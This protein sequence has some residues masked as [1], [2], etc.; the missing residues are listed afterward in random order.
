MNIAAQNKETDLCNVVIF[1]NLVVDEKNY[2][3]KVKGLSDS[4]RISRPAKSPLATYDVDEYFDNLNDE[5][6]ALLPVKERYAF[7]NIKSHYKRT[8]K[9][10][11]RLAG[12]YPNHAIK[13]GQVG[14]INVHWTSVI[15]LNIPGIKDAFPI[16]LNYNMLVPDCYPYLPMGELDQL[17]ESI[18]INSGISRYLDFVEMADYDK[19][20]LPDIIYYNEHSERKVI[21][22][23]AAPTEYFAAINDLYIQEICKVLISGK[24]AFNTVYRQEAFN[25]LRSHIIQS[26]KTCMISLIKRSMPLVIPSSEE[27]WV[28]NCGKTHQR[29]KFKYENTR[30]EITDLGFGSLCSKTGEDLISLEWVEFIADDEQIVIRVLERPVVERSNF[31]SM[32][33]Q[34]QYSGNGN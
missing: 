32:V 17:F 28:L 27:F 6:L 14:K 30:G 31:V 5:V 15:Y 1:E 13:L 34:Y 33:N 23:D 19:D 18:S 8:S 25:I 29:R 3:H 26:F 2:I 24:E 12:L 22:G 21:S 10:T 7:N 4:I 11:M 9:S 20:A 16:L